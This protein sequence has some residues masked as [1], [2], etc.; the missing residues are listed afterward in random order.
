MI[1]IQESGAYLFEYSQQRFYFC[2]ESV[3]LFFSLGKASFIMGFSVQK[4]NSERGIFHPFCF[5]FVQDECSFVSLREVERVL[6]V[7]AWFYQHKD[8]LYSLMNCKAE[9]EFGA[10]YQR[11]GEKFQY[12]V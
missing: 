10:L 11:D 1:T 4:K 2:R 5:P 9:E 7:M 6:S 3:L 8:V 12:K